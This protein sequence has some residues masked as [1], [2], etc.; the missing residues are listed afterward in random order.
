MTEFFQNLQAWASR[1]DWWRTFFSVLV[2]AVAVV[3]AIWLPARVLEYH[4]NQR[5]IR[6]VWYVIGSMILVMIYLC[7]YGY[8]R[9]WESD[10]QTGVR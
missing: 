9:F 4:T 7:M 8:G 6:Y 3:L 1:I 2:F 10:W 5:G